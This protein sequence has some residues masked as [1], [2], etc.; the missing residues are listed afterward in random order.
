MFLSGV[1]SVPLDESC[2]LLSSSV[3]QDGCFLPNTSLLFSLIVAITSPLRLIVRRFCR[4]PQCSVKRGTR[5][6]V[7]MPPSQGSKHPATRSLLRQ[8]WAYLP[9]RLYLSWR[10]WCWNAGIEEKL[11]AAW[12]ISTIKGKMLKNGGFISTE[13]GKKWPA[14]EKQAEKRRGGRLSVCIRCDSPRVDSSAETHRNWIQHPLLLRLPAPLPF[15]D[16]VPKLNPKSL[17]IC[18]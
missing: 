18:K 11:I 15:W 2:S 5:D 10:G 8:A 17:W 7:Q 6:A 14:L 1:V 4:V 12:I 3:S 9:K 13:V 16:S